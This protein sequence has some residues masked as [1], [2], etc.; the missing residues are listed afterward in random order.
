MKAVSAD[1]A[2]FRP[3]CDLNN[4]EYELIGK[5]RFRPSLIRSDSSA[6]SSTIVDTLTAAGLRAERQLKWIPDRHHDPRFVIWSR[7]KHAYEDITG[8]FQICAKFVSGTSIDDY[9]R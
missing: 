1:I 2:G 9:T 8:R 5:R 6:A 4:V 7:T 3:L